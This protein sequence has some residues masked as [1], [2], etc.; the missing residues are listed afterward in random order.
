MS[1]DELIG[2]FLTLYE[3]SNACSQTAG[4]KYFVYGKVHSVQGK[5]YWEKTISKDCP[6]GWED[7]I[8]YDFYQQG[9]LFYK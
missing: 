5:C 3:C 1:N 4:C 8:K 2:T 6:E 7:D 9:N